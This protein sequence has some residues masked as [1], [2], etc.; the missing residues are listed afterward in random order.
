MKTSKVTILIVAVAVTILL[1]VVDV[2]FLNF[3]ALS[4]LALLCGSVIR[5][6]SAMMIPL[7]VRAGTDIILQL[8]SGHGYFASWMF[9]YSALLLIFAIGRWVPNRNYFAVLFGGISATAVYFF[10]SNTGVWIMQPDWYPDR[11]IIGWIESLVAGIPF[12]RGTAIG[13][14]V[15]SLVFFGAWNVCTN[16]ASVEEPELAAV[17]SDIN[18]S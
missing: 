5:R 2:P 7:I 9:D 17:S 3:T 11:T 13:D 15:F 16:Q 8:K 6:P 18:H 12:A 10:L 14:V 1:R 4:A